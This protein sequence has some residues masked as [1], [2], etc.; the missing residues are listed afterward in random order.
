MHGTDIELHATVSSATESTRPEPVLRIGNDNDPRPYRPIWA[1]VACVGILGVIAP[2]TTLAQD[3]TKIDEGRTIAFDRSKGHCL[4]CHAIAGG[5]L[6]GNVGPV[7]V[8]MKARFPD[9]RK[10]REIIFDARSNNPYTIMPPFGPN[11]LLAGDEIDKVVEFILS[12]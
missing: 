3:S 12:L 9:K 4:A 10:L 1:V 7:L 11:K 5:E 2:V 6:P 8:A